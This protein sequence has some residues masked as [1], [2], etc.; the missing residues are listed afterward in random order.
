MPYLLL[1]V[2]TLA[3]T[4]KALFCKFAGSAGGRAAFFVNF[5]SFAVAFLVALIFAMDELDKIF[6]ISLFSL[7]LSAVF[8][9]F[10]AFTQFSQ[11]KA[12][13]SGPASL[14]MLIYSSAFVIPIIYAFFA[15][16]E[17]ISLWQIIGII[18]L[19]I[20]IALIVVEPSGSKINFLW[21]IFIAAATFGSGANAIIQ[22]THQM[23]E[24]KSELKLFL[25]LALMFSALFSLI[26]YLLYKPS[27]EKKEKARKKSF[28]EE[29]YPV[30]LG[31]AVGC[32]NFF[33]LM[34]AGLLP[35]VIQFP[36]YNVGSLILTSVFSLI[37]FKEKID[38]RRII[39]YITGV[40][41][42]LIIGIL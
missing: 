39:G 38:K 42:I 14:T 36:I 11:M 29:L 33:N 37:V 21:L 16:K 22:K 18:I 1:T 5:K 7:I 9:F 10:V 28:L 30:F 24:F 41:A 34:L 13:N 23:S 19:V 35:A 27:I 12:M 17:S 20:S 25:V 26:V 40:A 3:A 6:E 32:L 2:A 8:G 31:I 15:W 4:G